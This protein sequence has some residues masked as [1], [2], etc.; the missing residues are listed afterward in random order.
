M[1]VFDLV[2]R[3]G[4]HRFEGWFANSA[5]FEDQ[6]GRGLV[7]CPQCGSCEIEKAVMAPSLGRKGNQ[8]AT[9]TDQAKA[10]IASKLPPQVQEALGKLAQLQAQALKQSTWVG[11]QFADQSRAIHYGERADAPIH[12]QATAEEA[13]ALIDE[14]IPVMPL[15]FPVAP[16]EDVN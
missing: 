16:P 14:G 5:A 3:A 10:P 8:L 11:D 13:A 4:G 15:P 7:G 9:G 6:A 1:I 2:C 12:G